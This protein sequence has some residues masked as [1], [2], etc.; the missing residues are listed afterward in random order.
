MSRLGLVLGTA[1]GVGEGR[2]LLESDGEERSVGVDTPDGGFDES[3]NGLHS[4]VKLFVHGKAMGA[5]GNTGASK[6]SAGGTQ[7][8][9][10]NWLFRFC[11]I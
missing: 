8:V 9:G 4:V 3:W 7:P 11:G 2:L 10:S 5:A 6:V 1:E